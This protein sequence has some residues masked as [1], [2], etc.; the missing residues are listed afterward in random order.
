[1]SKRLLVLTVQTTGGPQGTVAAHRHDIA[2]R[3]G[4]APVDLLA[5]RH[6]ADNTAFTGGG[7]VTSSDLN[8]SGVGGRNAHN[9]L[10]QGRFPRAVHANKP[11]DTPRTKPKCG[12][13]QGLYRTVVHTQVLD[14]Q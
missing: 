7:R 8:G 9:R 2:H 14:V 1:M 12:V 10:E 11:A 4:K 5:L 6:V 13:V 3:Y